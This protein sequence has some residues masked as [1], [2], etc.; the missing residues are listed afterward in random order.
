[1]KTINQLSQYVEWEQ[2][3][4][5]SKPGCKNALNVKYIYSDICWSAAFWKV[6]CVSLFK[7][8]GSSLSRF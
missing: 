2:R 4:F 5:E 3:S 8:L 6:Y 1:M 7:L